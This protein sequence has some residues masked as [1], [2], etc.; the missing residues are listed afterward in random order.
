MMMLGGEPAEYARLVCL[1]RL[2]IRNNGVVGAAGL[3]VAGWA[4]DSI[5]LPILSRETEA[6]RAVQAENVA[7]VPSISKI[8]RSKAGCAVHTYTS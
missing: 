8:W 7:A 6:I 3:R 4:R 5:L 2:Q 1:G